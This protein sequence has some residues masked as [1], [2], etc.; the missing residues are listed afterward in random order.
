MNSRC[1]DTKKHLFYKIFREKTTEDFV[2]RDKTIATT[3]YCVS[4]SRL[5]LSNSS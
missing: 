5:S 1:K 4:Y 3:R 2:E